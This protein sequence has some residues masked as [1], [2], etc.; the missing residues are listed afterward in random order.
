MWNT[1]NRS[2]SR[3]SCRGTGAARSLVLKSWMTSHRRIAAAL[4]PRHH[5][6]VPEPDRPPRRWSRMWSR[7]VKYPSGLAASQVR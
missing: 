6:T 5:Y 7:P 4:A 1:F 3:N 2:R